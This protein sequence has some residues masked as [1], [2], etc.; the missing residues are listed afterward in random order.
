VDDVGV[1]VAE[2]LGAGEQRS[3]RRLLALVLELALAVLIRVNGV[4]AG[5]PPVDGDGPVDDPLVAPLRAHGLA[6]A[7]GAESGE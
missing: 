1:E 6:V 7:V 3:R 4:D 2:N 5:E